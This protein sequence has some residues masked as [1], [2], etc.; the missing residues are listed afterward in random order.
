[1]SEQPVTEPLID[2]ALTQFGELV[3]SVDDWQTQT[4]CEAWSI[5]ELV[6]HVTGNTARFA[7]MA[8]GE[9][10]DW[11]ASPEVG[12]DR[13]AAFD[14]AAEELRAAWREG[15]PAPVG[16][17]SGEY[18]V[19]TWD[20]ATALGRSTADLDS[21]LAESGLEFVHG[22]L[23]DDSR[24]EVFGPEKPAPQDADAYGTLAAFAGRT[25]S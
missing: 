13:V 16:M 9:E 24:G 3:G 14:A 12:T 8:R 22:N 18:A 4:P 23:T 2:T 5:G 10:V 21:S 11:S 15:S 1:M 25:V 17:A 19:H 20:L 6:D 7:T